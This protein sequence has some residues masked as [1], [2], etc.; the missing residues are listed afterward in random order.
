MLLQAGKVASV[1]MLMI[2]P[3]LSLTRIGNVPGAVVVA[4]EKL[5]QL[6]TE[7]PGQINGIQF[8]PKQP[9]QS[10]EVVCLSQ[11]YGPIPPDTVTL[12]L[13]SL[14]TVNGEQA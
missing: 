4:V 10:I 12:P 5:V 2:V 14:H 8:P 9:L 3:V 11:V 1:V 13:V 6:V 7:T